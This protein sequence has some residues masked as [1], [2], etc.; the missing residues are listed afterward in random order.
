MVCKTCEKL[1]AAYQISVRSYSEATGNL[2]GATK[3]DLIF[4]MEDTERL[5]KSCREAHA[6]LLEHWRAS[7]NAARAAGD[8]L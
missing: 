4:A 2:K 7:H 5:H 6:R 8:K 1:L 3:D